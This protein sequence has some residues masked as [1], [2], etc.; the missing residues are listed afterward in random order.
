L[1]DFLHW[2]ALAGALALGLG[3][4]AVVQA[5]RGNGSDELF[6]SL[7]AALLVVPGTWLL[8]R[9]VPEAQALSLPLMAGGATFSGLDDQTP[10]WISV[11]SALVVGLVVYLARQRFP[12]HAEARTPNTNSTEPA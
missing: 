10:L 5:A 2:R 8:V 11:T 6:F 7:W 12:S 9:G 1:R 3:V 4:A